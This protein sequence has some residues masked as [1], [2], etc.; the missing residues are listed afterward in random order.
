MINSP[1]R[2]RCTDSTAG[3][4]GSCGRT[5]EEVDTWRIM[6]DDEKKVVWKRLLADARFAETLKDA[7]LGD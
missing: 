6:T 3:A 7:Y 4:C 2:G 1:C 5:D